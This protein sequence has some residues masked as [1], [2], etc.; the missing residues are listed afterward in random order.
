[1]RF[2][3]R[4]WPPRQ[5]VEQYL[6]P[7]RARTGFEQFRQRFMQKSVTGYGYG[8]VTDSETVS[9]P[10]RKIFLLCDV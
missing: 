7:T 2:R 8:P 1:M 3:F 10:G 5:A 4:Q 9:K 6:V